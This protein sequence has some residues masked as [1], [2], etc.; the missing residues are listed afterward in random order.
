[1]DSKSELFAR[2]CSIV[3][4]ADQEQYQKLWECIDQYIIKDKL[5]A[6]RLGESINIYLDAK[7]AE[8]LSIRT[9]NN[10]LQSLTL[11][12]NYVGDILLAEIDTATIRSF[13]V[14][15]KDERHQKKSSV[16]TNLCAVRT[17]FGW[18]YNERFISENPLNRVKSTHIDKKSAR[19][20]MQPE[21]VERARNACITKRD[22]AM[23]EFFLS[24]GC[25]LSEV[26]NI[27]TEDIDFHN[28]SVVVTGKGDKQ[29]T[30][31]F[32]VRAKFFIEEYLNSD[33]KNKEYL[34]TSS[35]APYGKLSGQGIERI[36]QNIGRRANINERLYPH[37]LRHTFA[38]NAL[39]SGMDITSIQQLLGHSDLNTTQIYA[40]L[41]HSVVHSQYDRM[42][43]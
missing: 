37:K 43:S 32:S 23:F 19:H 42:V 35:C 26:S 5:T 21:N 31:Y 40:E 10:Y 25:R 27:K 1:M 20:P 28:R 2:I 36:F 24:T 11:L 16:Q 15:L 34:F 7:R 9:V 22:K 30:V 6:K 18:L 41:N 3:S 33:S 4:P 12:F 13:L 39:S 14:Y 29:R 38:T 8:G 17:F